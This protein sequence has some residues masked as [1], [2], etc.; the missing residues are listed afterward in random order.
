MLQP[1]VQ[2]T[3]APRGQTPIHYSWDRRDWLSAITVLPIR[4]RVGLYFN[5]L[6]HNIKADDVTPFLLKICWSIF[7]KGLSWSGL[8][9]WCTEVPPGNW[10]S[11]FKNRY[12]LNGFP[13]MPRNL[14]LTNRC[15]TGP[16]MPIWP[17]LFQKI[18]GICPRL[19]ADPCERAVLNNRCCVR[20]LTMLNCLYEH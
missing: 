13:P 19:Y 14:I 7:P 20:F 15:R 16:S 10:C 8:A 17:I 18:L 6:E 5:V 9:G 3:W 1:M 11:G 12:S 2:R 4:R